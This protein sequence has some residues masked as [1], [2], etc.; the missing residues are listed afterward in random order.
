LGDILVGLA[1]DRL[2]LGVLTDTNWHFGYGWRCKPPA[3][4]FHPASRQTAKDGTDEKA[5]LGA[6]HEFPAQ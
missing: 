3:G 1:L 4:T 5:W 6:D 2:S